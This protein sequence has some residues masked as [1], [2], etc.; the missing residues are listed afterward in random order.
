MSAYC[1]AGQTFV[2]AENTW[3]YN[4]AAV[5]TGSFPAIQ[6]LLL[7]E[8]S[9]AQLEGHS[10]VRI[11][12]DGKATSTPQTAFPHQSVCLMHGLAIK[13]RKFKWWNFKF[14]NPRL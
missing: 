14:C 4:L 5:Y 6:L 9:A 12:R 1:A 7:L 10:V 8:S 2:S 13:F 11:P 3:Q